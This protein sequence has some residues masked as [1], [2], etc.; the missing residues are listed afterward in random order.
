MRNIDPF[1]LKLMAGTYDRR[2]AK[3]TKGQSRL[4]TRAYRYAEQRAAAQAERAEM[5]RLVALIKLR[6]QSMRFDTV[7]INKALAETGRSVA[8]LLVA[9]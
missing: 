6:R 8:Y 5:D 9:Q 4:L 7:K 2:P 3:A 1:L